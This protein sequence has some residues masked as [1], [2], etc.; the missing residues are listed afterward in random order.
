MTDQEPEFHVLEN[1][2]TDTIVGSAVKDQFGTKPDWLDVSFFSEEYNEFFYIDQDGNIR[3][4]KPL[5]FESDPQH[6]ELQVHFW[7]VPD[8]PEGLIVEPLDY[9]VSFYI[10][11]TDQEPEF[12]VLE[13]QPADTIV[14]ALSNWYE[15]WLDVSLLTDSESEF[16][17]IDQ[18][19][20]IRTSKALDFES[21]PNHY[22]LKVHYF[23]YPPS[24]DSDLILGAMEGTQTF[25]ISIHD[26]IEGY[27]FW[28]SNDSDG[29]G[30]SNTEELLLG[31]DP[32]NH[33]SSRENMG[34]LAWYDFEGTN[35]DE[36]YRSEFISN[37]VTSE[38]AGK[39]HYAKAASFVTDRFG[40]SVS[41]FDFQGS[42]KIVADGPWPS[43]SSSRTVSVW[44]NAP[45]H[46]GNLFTFG[47]GRSRN[48]RFSLLMNGKGQDQV[49]LI[50]E[51]N[52]FVFRSNNLYNNWNQL[53]VT[54]DGNH[55][56]VYLNTE[57]LGSYQT[58]FNTDGSMPL[59]IGSNSLNRNDEFF[60]GSIDEM[61]VYDRALTEKDIMN[62]YNREANPY[63]FF[64]NRVSISEGL[65]AG[66][67]VAQIVPLDGVLQGSSFWFLYDNEE[68]QGKDGLI[69]RPAEGI[70]DHFEIDENGYIRTLYELAIPFWLEGDSWEHWG[71][72]VVED[73]FGYQHKQPIV[74]EVKKS[75]GGWQTSEWFGSF[76]PY[77]NG[78]LFHESLHWVYAQ[79]DLR[80]G[81]WLWLE[82]YGWLWTKEEVWPY[83]W[84]HE[85]KEWLYLIK[86]IDGVPLFYNYSKKSSEF[87]NQDDDLGPLIHPEK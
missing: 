85:T 34:L 21:D 12:H 2:P 45:S 43:G 53:V 32:N 26:N 84:K 52:D 80:G 22:E 75:Q 77:D 57:S 8:G 24:A 9:T 87:T 63:G 59:V 25:Y 68:L 69:F 70:F 14:G 15:D 48:A 19:R 55:G 73:R 72:V 46:F 37:K 35:E 76:R 4:N 39:I 49:A 3:T 29:D 33:N 78:W 56:N 23:G 64:S 50:G 81:L 83:L 82:H 17:Y 44:F 28:A 42:S 30:Y 18:D 54:Y 36:L 86:N 67:I 31:T 61:R 51:R 60:N 27:R 74:I 71:E 62:L 10:S 6:F 66:S 20:N 47:N 79:P 65:P 7:G 16:F 40:K 5:D 41:A 11:V 13:N 1:Q 38:Y 58:E